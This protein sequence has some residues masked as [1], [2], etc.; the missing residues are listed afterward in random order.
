M[1]A[2]GG[3]VCSAPNT[4]M[5]DARQYVPIAAGGTLTVFSLPDREM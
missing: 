4:F 5:L 3:P 1:K 2:T